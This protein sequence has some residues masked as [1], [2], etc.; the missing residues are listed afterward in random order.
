MNTLSYI[1]ITDPLGTWMRIPYS[2]GT[3]KKEK[4]TRCLMLDF[5]HTYEVT[6]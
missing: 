4:K 5:I 2:L 3:N 1:E 6:T